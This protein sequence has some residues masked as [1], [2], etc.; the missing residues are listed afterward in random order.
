MK[1]HKPPDVVRS[2]FLIP[3]YAAVVILIGIA[4]CA[5]DTIAFHRS[6]WAAALFIVCTTLP[7]LIA[8]DHL[9]RVCEPKRAEIDR[10]LL[11]LLEMTAKFDREHTEWIM[12]QRAQQRMRERRGFE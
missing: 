7:Q 8:N 10:R 6:A 5:P 1:R 9:W 4:S 12:E 2:R 11:E 3:A